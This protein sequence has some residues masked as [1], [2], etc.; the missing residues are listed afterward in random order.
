MHS[1]PYHEEN[2]FSRTKLVTDLF[3]SPV[4]CFQRICISPKPI[5]QYRKAC[6]QKYVRS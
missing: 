6:R 2:S 4:S 3:M 5:L 1:R